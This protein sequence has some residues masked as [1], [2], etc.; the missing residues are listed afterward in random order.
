MASW[1]S[2]FGLP[3]LDSAE[4]A[5]RLRRLCFDQDE[6]ERRTAMSDANT[7]DRRTAGLMQAAQAGDAEARSAA[8]RDHAPHTAD[9]ASPPRKSSGN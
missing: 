7:T 8:A 6:G 3:V 4:Q 1:P 2:H 5:E 9:R